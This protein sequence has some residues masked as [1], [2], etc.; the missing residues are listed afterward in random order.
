M[1]IRDINTKF[2]SSLDKGP[3]LIV[4]LGNV[5]DE[6]D[7]T[8][9]NAGFM[10]LDHFAHQFELGEFK[11]KADL[12]AEIIETNLAG[13]KLILA[14]PHTY[15]NKSGLAVVKLQ[16]YFSVNDP[17]ILIVY[18]D[19]DIDFSTVRSRTSGSSGG[20]NGIKSIE[21]VIGDSFARVRIGVKNDHLEHQDTADFVLTKFSRAEL[22]EL[23]HTLDY[24]NKQ[25]ELFIESQFEETSATIAP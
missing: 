4:G 13:E 14:K 21:Q 12:N 18:D 3:L 24:T 11:K 2:T 6:Y 17:R 25:I 20:H 7:K 19:I 5:G 16:N 15:M 1:A 9:H 22:S 23:K 10:A 8:R